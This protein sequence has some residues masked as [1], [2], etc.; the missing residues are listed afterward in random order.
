MVL[1]QI[2]DMRSSSVLSLDLDQV[3]SKPFG[4]DPTWPHPLSTALKYV[5]ALSREIRSPN[6]VKIT[7][8][9][10]NI[11]FYFISFNSVKS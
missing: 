5:A 2:A 7:L 9:S 1:D 8:C 10:Y 3:G 6:L 11:T 4:L